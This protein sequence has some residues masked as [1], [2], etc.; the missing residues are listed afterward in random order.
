MWDVY[1]P[2]SLLTVQKELS[3]HNFDLVEVHDVRLDRGS[4]EPRPEYSFSTRRGNENRDLV[5]IFLCIRESYQ[6][7][8]G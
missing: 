2:G 4:T 5:Q 7:L 3:E 8:I 6:Q 1:I